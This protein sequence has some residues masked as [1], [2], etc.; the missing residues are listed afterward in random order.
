MLRLGSSAAILIRDRDSR[1]GASF[2]RRVRA[3]G[4]GKL[5]RRLG[6]VEPMPSLR[7]G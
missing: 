2:D 3:S 4:Y 5:A 7:D 1:Y 6:R